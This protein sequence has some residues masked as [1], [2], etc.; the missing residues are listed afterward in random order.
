MPAAK[1]LINQ[2]PEADLATMNY[3]IDLLK[4]VTVRR[5]VLI[6]TIDVYGAK[7]HDGTLNEDSVPNPDN[8]Y[9]KHRCLFEL[10]IRKLI[11]RAIIIR[12]PGLFGKGLKKNPIYDMICNNRTAF[13]LPNSSFQWF[14]MS[15]LRD[16]MDKIVQL[17]LPLVNLF[18]AP[19]ST[20]LITECAKNSGFK[21]DEPADWEKKGANYHILTKYGSSLGSSV[22]NY[23]YDANTTVAC[24]KKFFWEERIRYSLGVSSI[25][26]NYSDPTE[27]ADVLS[28]FK[29]NDIKNIEIA[30]LTIWGTWENTKSALENGESRKFALDM[31]EQGFNITSMQGVHFMKPEVQLFANDDLFVEHFKL[32][33]DLAHSLSMNDR[34]IKIVFGSPKN[35]NPLPGPAV[36]SAENMDVAERKFNEIASY[37]ADKNAV[38]VIE[39][40]PSAYACEFLNTLSL[41]HDFVQQMNSPNIKFMVDTGCASLGQE[42]LSIVKG[43]FADNIEHV[44]LSQP[45][46]KP[47]PPT[48]EFE[49]QLDMIKSA[50]MKSTNWIIETRNTGDRQDLKNT[51]NAVKQNLTN[52]LQTL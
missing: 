45:F 13:I 4:T 27:T 35:R 32:L 47:F 33:I 23:I 26:W 43:S 7:D 11:P 6:S 36:H 28:F 8:A 41:V 44:H 16:Y 25:G 12:L 15:E 40:N 39:A 2:N 51:V 3:F 46:L 31:C 42:D 1:W 50:L 37:A 18:P 17:G 38:I 22:S 34:K 19:I 30:P 14:D 52:L 10:E 5:F 21:F 20:S 29:A 9:G 24:L 49:S 48:T